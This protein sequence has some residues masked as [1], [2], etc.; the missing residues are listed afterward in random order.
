MAYQSEELEH[1]HQGE[2]EEEGG[3]GAASPMTEQQVRDMVCV[4]AC[5]RACVR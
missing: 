3:E 2:E 4:C 1:R 5:V